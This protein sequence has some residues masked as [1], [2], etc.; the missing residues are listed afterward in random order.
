MKQ[1]SFLSVLKLW[2]IASFHFSLSLRF[3][4]NLLDNYTVE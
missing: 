4:A 2:L 3:I 1:S